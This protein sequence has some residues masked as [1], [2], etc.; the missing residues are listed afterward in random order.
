VEYLLKRNVFIRYEKE[1]V[2]DNVFIFSGDTNEMYQSNKEVYDV[3]ELIKRGIPMEEM[4]DELS[5]TYLESS[6]S[7]ISY[8]LDQIL[9]SLVELKVIEIV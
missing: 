4:V 9:N 3:L 7:E 6:P 2:G 1:L 8:E 5:Y